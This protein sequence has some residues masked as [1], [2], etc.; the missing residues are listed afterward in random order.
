MLAHKYKY[1]NFRDNNSSK[2]L[3]NIRAKSRA[4]CFF[5]FTL[6]IFVVIIILNVGTKHRISRILVGQDIAATREEYLSG[7]IEEQQSGDNGVVSDTL[8]NTGNA[9]MLNGLLDSAAANNQVG[10]I[11]SEEVD[12]D[13]SGDIPVTL[14]DNT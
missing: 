5:R 6:V 14:D 4:S 3:V 13:M 12:D 9:V 11:R 1:S 8:Q 10:E 7:V 2:N